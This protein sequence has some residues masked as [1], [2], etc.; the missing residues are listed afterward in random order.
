MADISEQSLF[1]RNDAIPT[2]VV[3]GELVALDLERGE[4]F[5]MDRVGTKIWEMTASP[6]S[7]DAMI[8]RLAMEYEVDREDCARDLLPFLAELA[9]AGLFRV[10]EK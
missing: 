9:D 10:L 1:I 4:C 3:D 8:T 7:F 6:I 2:G 5:G